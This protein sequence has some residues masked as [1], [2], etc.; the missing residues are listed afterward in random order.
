MSRRSF[1]KHLLSL[2]ASHALLGTAW[3]SKAVSFQIA[4]VVRH[5][6]LQLNEYCKDLKLE[7][8]PFLVWQNQV[9]K[10]L[11]NVPLEELIQFISFDQLIQGFSLP[12]KG[13][14]TKPVVLPKLSD[15]PT[16]TLFVKKI[17]GMKKD[18]AIIPHGHS[19]MASAHLVLSGQMHLRHY[20]KT[21]QN[22]TH[23]WVAPS[24]DRMVGPGSCSSIS[25]ERD[26]VHWFIAQS[27][28]AFTLDIIMLDLHQQSYDI[29][30]LDMYEAVPESNGSLRAPIMNVEEALEKYGH[31]Q[32]H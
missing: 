17:F 8:M 12:D 10:L 14:K 21:H 16:D 19:H 26:N 20:D 31:H 15:L 1:Q 30:N 13:V 3:E 7:K 23:C 24:Q 11:R 27:E 5:W 28:V 29:Q 32:H 2:L 18:R 9:E 25:D 22:H 4:P 6:I